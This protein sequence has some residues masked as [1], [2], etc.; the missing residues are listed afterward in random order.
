MLPMLLTTTSM[1]MTLFK[2]RKIRIIFFYRQAELLH[3]III[4]ACYSAI[5]TLRCFAL[6]SIYVECIMYGCAGELNSEL[7]VWVCWT[8][9]ELNGPIYVIFLLL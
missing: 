3:S 1:I 4:G 5:C 9:G 8:A 6:L 7:N 2:W